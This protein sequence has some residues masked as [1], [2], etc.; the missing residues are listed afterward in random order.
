M[1]GS[2]G[3]K[4]GLVS[5]TIWGLYL[6]A[7]LLP[8]A[9]F[10][11]RG[12]VI[13]GYQAFQNGWQGAGTIPELANVALLVGWIAYLYNKAFVLA[14]GWLAFGLGLTAPP[15]YGLGFAN[16]GLGYYLWMASFVVLT[17]AAYLDQCPAGGD[18][19]FPK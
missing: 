18:S 14:C 10:G 12:Y 4:R 7:L 5:I 3:I 15:I 17:G 16:L 8:A 2:S 6:A 19:E 13:P 9:H 1:L 11:E